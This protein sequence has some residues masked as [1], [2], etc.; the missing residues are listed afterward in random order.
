MIKSSIEK[1]AYD[2]GFDIGNSDDVTQAKLLN[3]LSSGLS[4][5]SDTGYEKQICYI[6]EHLTK[7]SF[8]I[9]ESLNEFVQLKIEEQKE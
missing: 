7:E 3:G 4:K 5:I 9:I 1:L 6:A 2:I 8:K